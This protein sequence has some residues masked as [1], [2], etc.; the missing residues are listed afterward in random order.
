MKGGITSGVIYP[1]LIAKLSQVYDLR[2]IGG[3]SAG[4]I[5]AG[6]A[7]AAQ[8]GVHAGTNQAAFD[9]VDAL[10]GILSSEAKGEG[11]KGSVLLNLFQPQQSTRR[12][13][14][15]LVGMLNAPSNW[16]ARPPVVRARSGSAIVAHRF[17]QR[18]EREQQSQRHGLWTK[19]DE[20]DAGY[21]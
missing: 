2:N 20:G 10:P 9:K 1:K 18:G 19:L 17:E 4:A 11:R 13:F 14:S 8:L 21:R 3:T 15:F 5:A 6:A 7:A 12:H 16:P